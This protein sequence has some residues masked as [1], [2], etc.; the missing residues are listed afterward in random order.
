MLLAR[1]RNHPARLR[2]KAVA[3]TSHA[4]SARLLRDAFPDLVWHPGTSGNVDTHYQDREIRG[5][6]C[7]TPAEAMLLHH[8]ARLAA[9][10]AALEIGSYIGW[11]TAHIASALPRGVLTCVDPFLETGAGGAEA[12]ARAQARFAENIGRAGLADKVRLV[13]DK[14]PEVLPAI[15]RDARW[16]F[17]LVDGWHLGG[18]PLRDVLGVQPFLAE[19]PVLLLH[20]LWIP[21]VRDA[22]AHLVARGWGCHVFDTAN[23]LALLWPGAA[24]AWLP[25]LRGI[26]EAP[27]FVLPA[28][29]GRR[30]L[31]GLGADSIEVIRLSSGRPAA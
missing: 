27:A 4:L 18:A 9:P 30:F 17:V 16:D 29:R 20:D 19:R 13:R 14:S 28:A 8:A 24:P 31:L 2:R 25:E 15:S 3:R 10:A 11:S 6:V 22:F 7:C 1:L 26:A 21:D 12:G 5:A 23:Y